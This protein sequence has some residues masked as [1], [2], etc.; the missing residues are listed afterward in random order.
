MIKR[1]SVPDQNAANVLKLT[2]GDTGC[3]GDTR[4]A[5]QY[6]ATYTQADALTA[7]NILDD[8]GNAKALTVAPASTSAA[9]VQ[10]AILA[11]L[12]AYG[13]EDDDN[14]TF[15]GVVVTDLGSTLQVVVTGDITMVSLTNAGGTA[16]FDADC[17]LLYA[18]TFAIT[19]YAGGSA[20]TAATDLYV[21]GVAYNLGAITPGS[22]T[23]GAVSTA[24]QTALTTAGVQGTAATTTTGSGG[25]Q[26]YNITITTSEN[27]NIF[28]LNTIV[29]TKSAC[30]QIYI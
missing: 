20:S 16:S 25:S 13:A 30:A 27:A 3:C 5:C 19:G 14:P 18:C 4:T 8:A 2:A 7:V 22:T 9:N 29:L 24:V 10:A 23:S 6:T 12:I 28:I 21:N 17:T 11:A 15:P 1:F 26:T